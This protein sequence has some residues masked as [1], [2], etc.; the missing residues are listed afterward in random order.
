MRPA[1]IIRAVN[2]RCAVGELA[3][4]VAGILIAP[5]ISDCHE[6]RAPR[7]RE[8]SRPPYDPSFD[9][10]FGAAC[11]LLPNAVGGVG[12]EQPPLL[13][14]KIEVLLNPEDLRDRILGPKARF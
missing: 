14:T 6:Q 11:G 10:L 5:A 3:L 4:L 2:L 8:L 9:G 12:P 1:K 7:E 13:T